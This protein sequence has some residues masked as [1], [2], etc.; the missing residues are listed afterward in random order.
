VKKE[1]GLK[2]EGKRREI[3]FWRLLSVSRHSR[4][5]DADMFRTAMGRI[6]TKEEEEKESPFRKGKEPLYWIG[7][8][9]LQTLPKKKWRDQGGSPWEDLF[10]HFPGSK[11]ICRRGM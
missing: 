8:E 9:T 4:P 1:E 2:T 6:N 10:S 7:K 5:E 3:L 11:G